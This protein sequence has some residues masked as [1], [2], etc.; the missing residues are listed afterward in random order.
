M[1]KDRKFECKLYSALGLPF[2]NVSCD[3]I[4]TY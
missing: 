2:P 4:N 3:M 1:R